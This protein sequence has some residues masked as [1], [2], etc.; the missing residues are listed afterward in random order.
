MK[1]LITS[2]VFAFVPLLSFCQDSKDYVINLQGDTLR[3]TVRILSMDQ[4]DQV[5]IVIN[6]KKTFLTALKVKAIFFKNETY[7]SVRY[8]N[9][10]KFMKVVKSGFLSLYGF[11]LPN[12]TR[13]D[14][15]LLAKKG[16]ETMEV[17]N[18]AFKKAMIGFLS[19][20]ESVT[21]ALKNE[22]LKAK[23]L[24][25]IIDKFNACMDTKKGNNATV[26]P[27]DSS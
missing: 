22:T 17:P 13:Y 10:Q 24:N 25:E 1:N 16:G 21:E 15:R 26:R 11:P 7:H 19:E 23:D 9:T 8:S 20:C 5:R 4:I 3:G 2:L 27:L 18:L 12:Q 6:K 14:G